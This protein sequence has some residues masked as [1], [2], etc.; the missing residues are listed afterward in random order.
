[1]ITLL[2][3]NGYAILEI[4]CDQYIGILD[5]QLRTNCEERIFCI[6]NPPVYRASRRLTETRIPKKQ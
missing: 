1:M 6:R 5:T 4:W 2:F 3:V